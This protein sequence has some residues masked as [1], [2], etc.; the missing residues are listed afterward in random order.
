MHKKERK[1]ATIQ[2]SAPF[3]GDRKGRWA[4]VKAF[5]PPGVLHQLFYCSR[6]A[7]RR[8]IETNVQ[9]IEGICY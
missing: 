5:Q 9:H 7:L 1:D 8:S 2:L 3:A 6:V 4:G